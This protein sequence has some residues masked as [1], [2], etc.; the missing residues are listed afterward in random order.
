MHNKQLHDDRRLLN[1][2]NLNIWGNSSLTKPL[3]GKLIRQSMKVPIHSAAA[4]GGMTNPN[5]VQEGSE[6]NLVHYN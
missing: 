6:N 4:T 1:V 2:K 5:N 3:S